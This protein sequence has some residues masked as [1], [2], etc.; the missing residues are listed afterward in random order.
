MGRWSRSSVVGADGVELA[1]HAQGPPEAPVVLLVHGFPDDHHVWDLVAADLATDHRVIAHDVRGAG[2]SGVPTL[3]DGYRMMAL[4]EDIDAVATSVMAS[5]AGDGRVHLVGHDWGSIQS[6]AAALHP[7]FGERFA[8]YTSISAPPLQHV[9]PWRTA[10]L[11]AGPPGWWAMANQAL[12]SSY[13]PAFHT[14]LAARVWRRWVAPRWRGQLEGLGAIT[15]DD[16]PSANIADDGARGL[17][18]YRANIGVLHPRALPPIAPPTDV[19]VQLL[20]ALEDPHVTPPLLDG[21]DALA[22][23]FTRTE[24]AAGHWVP[25]THPV[26]VAAAVRTHVAAHP[27]G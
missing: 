27:A 23:S 8:S 25:R 17:E 5:V 14:R 15:D 19:P 3:L 24:V 6:W 22:T 7:Q 1:V 12:R 26:E 16:W 2:A 9:G 11:A 10:K 13:I 18:L 21:L 4:I 20:V